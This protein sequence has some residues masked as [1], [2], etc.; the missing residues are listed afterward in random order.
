MATFKKVKKAVKKA[1]KAVS[2][3]KTT[4]T[5]K[6]IKNMHALVDAISAKEGTGIVILIDTKNNK[7]TSYMNQVNS[8]EVAATLLGSIDG[9]ADE[10]MPIMIKMFLLNK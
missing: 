10:V 7:G 5:A 2:K 4:A 9:H 3:K 1:V 6:D 8:P